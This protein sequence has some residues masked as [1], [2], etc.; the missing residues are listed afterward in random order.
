MGAVKIIVSKEL[1][2]ELTKTG[3]KL[4][5]CVCTAGLPDNCRLSGAGLDINNDLLLRFDGED[6]PECQPGEKPQ[7]M[8]PIYESTAG[9]TK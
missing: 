6:L 8:S 4:E 3:A 9:E 7:T 2:I 5:P 1:V